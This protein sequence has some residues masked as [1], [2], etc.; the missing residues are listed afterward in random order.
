M[1][2]VREFNPPRGGRYRVPSPPSGIYRPSFAVGREAS[3][4][5]RERLRRLK[6]GK[7]APHGR[8][9][10]NR[11]HGNMT[12]HEA[13]EKAG[14]GVRRAGGLLAS[15]GRAVGRG[16][17]AAA[18]GAASFAHGAAAGAK[19]NAAVAAPPKKRRAKKAAAKKPKKAAAKKPK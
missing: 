8:V 13:G 14:R 18:R 16:A 4:I 5:V 17:V 2:I 6:I 12:A 11:T 9:L 15:A 19:S 3:D 7:Q 10:L 1:S